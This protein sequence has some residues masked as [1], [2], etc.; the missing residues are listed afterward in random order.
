MTNTFVTDPS[1]QKFGCTNVLKDNF[2]LLT[3]VSELVRQNFLLVVLDASFLFRSF[4]F[5]TVGPEAVQFLAN[6]FGTFVSE[7]S[8][9]NFE[10][11]TSVSEL[12]IYG[13]GFG[14]SISQLSCHSS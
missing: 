11:I 14:T 3:L 10:I 2:R 7:F 5:I 4:D 1:L 8:N 13:F 6:V 12:M 9:R